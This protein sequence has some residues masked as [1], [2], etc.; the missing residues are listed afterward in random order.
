MII[1]F[2]VASLHFPQN[3]ENA[4]GSGG[5]VARWS[6]IANDPSEIKKPGEFGHQ[7]NYVSSHGKL[8][9]GPYMF[10]PKNGCQ[11][12]SPEVIDY[13]ARINSHDVLQRICE[14]LCCCAKVECALLTLVNV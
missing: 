7:T 14:M 10:R 1:S 8:I 12:I 13:S 5:N 11:L 9:E 6:S 3:S 4:C 2:V